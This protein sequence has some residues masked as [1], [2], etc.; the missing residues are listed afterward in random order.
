VAK[1]GQAITQARWPAIVA[2]VGLTGCSL[3]LPDELVLGP[4]WVIPGLVGV[5]VVGTYAAHRAGKHLFDRLGGYAISSIVTL[6]L[7][8][9]IVRLVM[10]LPDKS[11][12]PAVLL[13]SASLLWLTNL[14]VFALWYWRLDGGGPHAREK[15]GRHTEG[16]FFFPQMTPGGDLGKDENWMP[17]FVDYLFVAFAT[18]TTLGPTDTAIMSRWAKVLTMVQSLISLVCVGVLL[19]RGVGLL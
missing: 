11:E 16:A 14:L 2:V 9:A 18:S 7:V 10:S 19:S 8:Y 5:L 17:N 6:A 15:R 13:R 3:A 4:R 12:P 1:P